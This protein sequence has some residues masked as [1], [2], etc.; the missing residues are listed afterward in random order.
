MMSKK[1]D[2]VYHA[3]QSAQRTANSSDYFGFLTKAPRNDSTEKISYEF[4][5]STLQAINS[6]Y[7][8]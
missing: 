3:R 2:G 7:N 6:C 8:P 5:A 1:A 4:C